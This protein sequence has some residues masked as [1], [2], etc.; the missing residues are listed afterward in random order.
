MAYVMMLFLLIILTA[1]G[2]S[3]LLRVS[4]ETSATMARANN[5]QVA[6]LAEAG[7]NHAKWRLLNDTSFPADEDTYYMH[8]LAGGRYGYKVRRHTDTTFA[9][10]ASIGV[11]G[12][13]VV[14]QSY[15]L[16]VIPQ[17]MDGLLGW[18]KLDEATGTTAA[19]STP[20]SND[21]TL[22][23]M[24]GDEWN[25]GHVDGALCF[26]G[27]DDYVDIGAVTGTIKSIAFWIQAN[28]LGGGSVDSGFITPT[29]AGDDVDE[30]S[31]P[32]KAFVSDDDWSKEKYNGEQQDW[33]NF[34]FGIPAGAVIDGIEAE[35]EGRHQNGSESGV[36]IELSW[37]GG[38]TYTASGYGYI[39]SDT[40]DVVRTF[41]GAADG[42][43]RAWADTELSDA[44]FRLRVEKQGQDNR[45]HNIDHLKVKVHYTSAGT[46]KVLDLDG[47]DYIEIVGAAI[48]PVSFPGVSTVYVDGIAGSTVTTS[49]HHITITNDTGLSATDLEFARVATSYF[50]GCHDDLRLYDRELTTTEIATLAGM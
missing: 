2:L 12:D 6:Y 15:V 19:D 42:W 1:L 36:T 18:W 45:F 17:L 33:Y 26:D 40:S 47:S 29:A 10:V 8:S 41:G 39:T 25:A 14:Q 4:A 46:S 3:F 7:A 9:T 23:N 44:N 35:I 5:I 28:S 34:G 11:L 48:T 20:A 49:W 32:T 43:G 38:A 30:W 16:Y 24:V 31:N 50:D 13:D 22:T 21:G 37:D 27:T